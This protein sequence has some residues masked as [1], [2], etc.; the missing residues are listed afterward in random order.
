V[1]G[2]QGDVERHGPESFRQSEIDEIKRLQEIEE[3]KALR[4]QNERRLRKAILPP[5]LFDQLEPGAIPAMTDEAARNIPIVGPLAEAGLSAMTSQESQD[6]RE[7]WRINNIRKYPDLMQAAAITGGLGG[8]MMLP[9]PAKN[10]GGM[11]GSLARVGETS[12][13]T[14]TDDILRGGGEPIATGIGSAAIAAIPEFGSL[15]KI[16]RIVGGIPEEMSDYYVKNRRA[17][18]TARPSV[19]VAESMAK[20]GRR[21][22]GEISAGSGESY[23]TLRESGV[24]YPIDSVLE[25][26]DKARNRISEL[27]AFGKGEQALMKEIDRLGYKIM[28]ES[29]GLKTVD[30]EKVKSFITA[31]RSS[32]DA[33][34]TGKLGLAHPAGEGYVKSILKESDRD[35]N[36]VLKDLVPEYGDQ[37]S[38]VSKAV[39]VVKPV[40]RVLSDETTA[41]RYMKRIMSGKDP[42]GMKVSRK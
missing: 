32:T 18:N 28:E 14:T 39:R 22:Q 27:G 19:D 37:M 38:R 26:L 12:A 41:R 9:S 7:R 10:I 24:N 17:V 2:N 23:R 13:I 29:K 20:A 1:A 31:Y 40:E 30:P 5:T 33:Y 35:M 16:N 15:K 8:S 34:R 25:A 21:V 11:T 3:I 6:A 36:G 4:A 42:A